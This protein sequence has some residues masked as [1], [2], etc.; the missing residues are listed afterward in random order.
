MANTNYGEV[1]CQAV[2]EIVQKR[3]EGVSY[4][5]TILCTIIDD[6]KKAEGLYIVSNNG[7]VKFEAYSDNT[8][9]RKNDNVYVH[10]P[11]GDW[12]QQKTIVSKKTNKKD[13]PFIYKR[14]FETLV[15]ITGNVIAEAVSARGLTANDEDTM[16]VLLWEKVEVLSSYT[17]L[18]I[19]AGFKSLLNP[20]YDDNGNI[21]NVDSGD[22]GLKLTLTTKQDKTSEESKDVVSDYVIYLN[23]EDMNGNP[24]DFQ[25]YYIQEK[26]VDISQ[27]GTIT[28]MKLEFYQTQGTFKSGDKI[29]P[30]KDFLGNKLLPNLFVNEPYISLGYDTADFEDE[31]VLVYTLDTSTYSRNSEKNY[32]DI[33]LRWIHKLDDGTFKSIGPSE[34]MEFEVR[35]YKFELGH[36]SADE[37]SGV[38]WK[39][40]SKQEHYYGAG[41]DQWNNYIIIDEEYKALV[42]NNTS[43]NPSFFNTKLIVDNGMQNEQ[44][45]AIII[46]D[47]KPYRSNI[48]KFENEN[49]V[50]NKATI[51]AI[52]ALSIQCDDNTYGNYRIYGQNGQLLD[53]ADARKPRTWVPYFRS[54][55]EGEDVA[56]T[57]LFEAEEVEWIIPTKNTMLKVD[58]SGF[59]EDDISYEQN[60]DERVHIKLYPDND[61]NTKDFPLSYTINSYYSQNY[62]DNT[63]QCKIVKNGITYTAVKEHTF[64]PSGTMGS[65]CTFVLDFEGNAVALTTGDTETAVIVVAKLYD[66]ENNEVDIS[67]KTIDWGW[68]NEEDDDNEIIERVDNGVRT[69]LKLKTNSVEVNYN[70]LKASITWGD[71]ELVAYLPIPIRTSTDY[72]YISGAT[73]V[74]YDSDGNISNLYAN[75]YVLYEADGTEIPASWEVI[76]NNTNEDGIK[77]VDTNGKEHIKYIY[78]PKISADNSLKPLNFYVE[79]AC[80]EVCIIAKVDGSIVWLQPLLIMQNKYPSAM[81][82][83]WDGNLDVGETDKGTILAPRLVAGK[84]NSDNTFSGVMMGDW[85]QTNSDN[86]ITSTTGIYGFSSG[87]QSFAFKE[88]G[89]AF[90]GKSGAGR[91]EFDGTKSIIE[92]NAYQAGYG[93]SINLLAGTID[94]HSFTLSAGRDNDYNWFNPTQGADRTIF[95]DTNADFYPLQI[96]SNFYVDWNGNVTV[97]SG[98]FTGTIQA[99]GGYIGG[100]SIN[101]SALTNGSTTLGADGSININNKFTVNSDGVLRASDVQISGQIEADSG[102]I[103]EWY[104]TE[105]GDLVTRTYLDPNVVNLGMKLSQSGAIETKSENFIVDMYGEITAKSGIIGG[106]NIDN[107]PASDSNMGL[108]KLIYADLGSKKYAAFDAGAGGVTIAVGIPSS[109]FRLN[110]RAASFWVDNNGNCTTNDLTVNGT[111]SFTDLTIAG[112]FNT[113]SFDIDDGGTLILNQTISTINTSSYGTRCFSLDTSGNMETVS[114]TA[115]S[116]TTKTLQVGNYT[117]KNRTYIPTGYYFDT[118]QYTFAVVN[119]VYSFPYVIIDNNTY[120][121]Y[122]LQNTQFN[123]P[124]NISAN[125]GVYALTE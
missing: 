54:A 39:N 33:Q 80:E 100:W 95:I 15:D 35:W 42:N 115:D 48:L 14:P 41:I 13:E 32:K 92:S 47:G 2:D 105:N 89:T 118:I 49:E 3:L 90:I 31:K 46:Y 77:Y 9:Y 102:R 18:G 12:N 91:I 81:V 58:V 43:L 110:H 68:K 23:C 36:S 117:Y 66:Y 10:I 60:N 4:D 71:G 28:S 45:K 103:G 16:S 8:S 107:T 37:Y 106:W 62:S 113:P 75:P 26:V 21:Y 124:Y 82:N 96:G 50:V 67:D 87:E 44:I 79:N 121:V 86:S 74:I 120:Q 76:N 69:E 53:Q 20:F 88:D 11:G 93:M 52:Q 17:R 30:Y 98:T 112:D 6:D 59:N 84:K 38:Y 51:D 5:Q 123:I 40:W 29:L 7:T 55:T 83:Q 22:Y 119:S 85:S 108:Y 19:Q 111:M 109:S 125:S 1:L 101:N 56:P 70:I 65:D 61:P 104:I 27:I 24:Y 64:G 25:T 63:I 114:F 97:N 72:A 73:Q 94:A 57:E 99:S 78:T 34:E 122:G 116:L